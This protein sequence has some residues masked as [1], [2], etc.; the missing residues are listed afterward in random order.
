MPSPLAPRK[1]EAFHLNVLVGDE[2]LADYA[3]LGP[4]LLGQ[5]RQQL[6][7]H[8]RHFAFHFSEVAGMIAG[9]SYEGDPEAEALLYDMDSGGFLDRPT[10]G[11]R[12][13]L[14]P[15]GPTGSVSD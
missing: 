15:A 3:L 1:I 7:A 2:P 6:R 4:I 13:E 14:W 8:S 11:T 10:D 5:S 9:L 12:A